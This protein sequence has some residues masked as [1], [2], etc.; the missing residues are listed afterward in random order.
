MSL[1][2]QL[3]TRASSLAPRSI[4]HSCS[5]ELAAAVRKDSSEFSVDGGWGW[6]E[7]LERTGY[8]CSVISLSPPGGSLLLARGGVCVISNLSTTKREVRESLQQGLPFLHSSSSL[9]SLLYFSASSLSP[10]LIPFTPPPQLPSSPSHL[11]T[12][13]KSTPLLT[14]KALPVTTC[15]VGDGTDFGTV[16]KDPW[17][18]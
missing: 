1:I 3:V 15:S 2:L 4:F 8:T 6:C 10:L 11:Y 9:S 13:G 18:P 17:L 12:V 16:T 5:T 7:G 14:G